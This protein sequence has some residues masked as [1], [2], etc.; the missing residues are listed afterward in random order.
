MKRGAEYRRPGIPTRLVT[1]L[2]RFVFQVR[3][4]QSARVLPANPEVKKMFMASFNATVESYRALLLNVGAGRLDLPNQN[5]DLGAPASS[6]QY[7][8]TDLAYDKLLDKL[9]DHKF[10]GTPADLR[11]NILDYLQGPEAARFLHAQKG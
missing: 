5:L 10:S 11:S 8:G 3:P 7:L 1:G 2:L 9:S 6:G 4:V